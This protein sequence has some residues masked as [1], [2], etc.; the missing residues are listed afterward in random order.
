MS[1]T[2]SVDQWWGRLAKSQSILP[3]FLSGAVEPP[4]KK[5]QYLTCYNLFKEPEQSRSR[6]HC[7]TS[8]LT[9]MHRQERREEWIIGS[10]WEVNPGSIMSQSC[11]KQQHIQGLRK[12]TDG[13]LYT[14]EQQYSLHWQRADDSEQ[15][16]RPR[17]ESNRKRGEPGECYL[18]T[19]TSAG[20]PADSLFSPQLIWRN[21][22]EDCQ[23]KQVYWIGCQTY[24]S[25]ELYP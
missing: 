19:C 14:K 22:T 23:A 21:A 13:Q 15:R 18:S 9:T 5:Y 25:V 24:C 16:K 20:C 6:F 7:R 17:Q 1:H 11:A 4:W 10:C 12:R 8:P 2:S 3:R